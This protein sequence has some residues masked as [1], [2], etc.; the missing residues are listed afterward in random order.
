L[1]VPQISKLLI[2]PDVAATPRK[3][4][5]L[6]VG[7]IVLL[8]MVVIVVA[9][10]MIMHSD[11]ATPAPV[12]SSEVAKTPEPPPQPA[13]ETK[14]EPK[15]TAKAEKPPEP[16]KKSEPV[17]DPAPPA[18]QTA[19]PVTGIVAQPLPDITDQARST[20]HGRVRIT[21]RVDVGPSGSVTDAKLDSGSS[22][23]LGERA[24]EAVRQWKFEPVTV[25]GSDVGQRWRVRFEFQKSGT[26]ALPQRLSP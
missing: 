14:P 26:K 11:T 13:P 1:T 25:N 8:A 18:A 5:Y 21:V 2:D 12:K 15:K 4:R 7:V 9:G 16:D 6:P 17:A 20:I 3:K 23:Y 19:V 22:K 24:L 10:V